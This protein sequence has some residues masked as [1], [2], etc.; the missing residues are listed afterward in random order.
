MAGCRF[1]RAYD[2]IIA[3]SMDPPVWWMR[4]DPAWLKSPSRNETVRTRYRANS[5][6]ML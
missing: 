2:K 5:P 3:D 1:L 4:D 6:P